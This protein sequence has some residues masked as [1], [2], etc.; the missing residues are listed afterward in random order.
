MVRELYDQQKIR[1]V[2]INYCRGVDRMDRDL[3]LSCYHP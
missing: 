2:V 3:F 1:D